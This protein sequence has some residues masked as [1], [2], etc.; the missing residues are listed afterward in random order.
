MSAKLCE[1][2][3]CSPVGS[4]HKAEKWRRSKFPSREAEAWGC[5][6]RL[7]RCGSSSASVSRSGEAQRTLP[8]RVG[9]SN[10]GRGEHSPSS[11]RTPGAFHM[12]RQPKEWI[13]LGLVEVSSS[14]NHRPHGTSQGRRERDRSRLSRGPL[15]SLRD[16]S[17]LRLCSLFWHYPQVTGGRGWSPRR[18]QGGRDAGGVLAV[19]L[20]DAANSR[21]HVPPHQGF[22]AQDLT[23]SQGKFWMEVN[24]F[25]GAWV[26][27]LT[28]NFGSGW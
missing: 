6:G 15:V 17:A 26:A 1:C 24:R 18:T 14:R 7:S 16:S 23:L 13:L 8:K 22:C 5:G 3:L 4:F 21:S 9:E 19:A 11:G 27:Q 10:K 25:W 28:L 2:E 20:P 12:A